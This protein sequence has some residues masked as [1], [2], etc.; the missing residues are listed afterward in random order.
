MP[1]DLGALEKSLGSSTG[2]CYIVGK[3]LITRVLPRLLGPAA[4][5]CYIDQ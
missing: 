5:P 3:S 1:S 2:P 4:R